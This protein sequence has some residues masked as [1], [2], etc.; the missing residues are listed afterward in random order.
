MLI[1]PVGAL[2]SDSIFL[3]VFC[4]VFF[5]KSFFLLKKRGRFSR[6]AEGKIYCLAKNKIMRPFRFSRVKVWPVQKMNT[7]T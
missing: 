5:V 7:E 2:D 1:V 4:Q 6:L 3:H